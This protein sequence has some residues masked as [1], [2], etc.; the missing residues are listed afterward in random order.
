ME[1]QRF[2]LIIRTSIVLLAIAFTTACNKNNTRIKVEAP[3]LKGQNV[4]IEEQRVD[5]KKE[6]EQVTLST[7]GKLSYK[8]DLKQPKFYNLVFEEDIKLFLL[9]NPEDEIQVLL[10]DN[11]FEIKG[12]QESE[13][14][15]LLYDSLYATR[16][17]LDDYRKQYNLSIDQEQ[18]DSLSVLYSQT[19]QQHYKFSVQ[20]VLDNLTSLTSVAAVYQELA[21]NT[22]VFGSS[23]DLQFFKLVSDSLTKRYPKN[24][25][26]LALQRNFNSMLKNYNM[27]KL[28]NSVDVIEQDLPAIE[29]PDMNG[30]PQSLSEIEKRYVF[31]NIWSPNDQVSSQLFPSYKKTYN[32]FKNKGFTVYN[33]YVGKSL[34]EWKKVIRFEEIESWVNV[35]DT[36]FPNSHLKGAY[37]VQRV[38]ANYLIDQKEETVVGRDMSPAQLNQKL[39]TLLN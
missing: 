16:A 11:G 25:H 17:V 3:E 38:P 10:N 26:V 5:G 28:L 1:K 30:N 12:S 19:V 23:K 4:T 2:T 37:N 39:S 31:I 6:I 14:L 29:L 33:V 27:D 24:R 8:M 32:S 7:K 21:P 34:E 15:N 35:A 9:V 20:F 36:N 22:F 13:N 18:Q